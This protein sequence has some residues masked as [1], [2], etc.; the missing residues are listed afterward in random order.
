[1]GLA[2]KILYTVE[3]EYRLPCADEKKYYDGFYE[4]MGQVSVNHIWVSCAYIDYPL[5]AQSMGCVDID[6]L[7]PLHV[8]SDVIPF[9]SLWHR[10]SQF[11]GGYD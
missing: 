3:L 7:R 9:F 4:R 5:T 10:I 2:F 8:D 11:R 1:M 6:L